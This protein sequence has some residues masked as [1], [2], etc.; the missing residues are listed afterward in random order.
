MKIGFAIPRRKR[1]IGKDEMPSWWRAVNSQSEHDRNYMAFLAFTGCRLTES[2]TLDWR[3][4]NLKR[5]IFTL[6]NPKNHEADVILPLPDIVLRMIRPHS[7]KTGPVFAV[8][9]VP[10]LIEKVRRESGVQFSAHDLR[11]TFITTGNSLDI[12]VY[13]IKTLVNH[14]VSASDVTGRYD[15]P[16]AD[17][18]KSASR[19]I[20]TEL[21]RQMVNLTTNVIHINK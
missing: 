16:S 18:L 5:G 10:W 2:K 7:A 9:G 11:R 6:V 17:R 15:I 1:V 8:G 14:K 19:R 21:L 12:S 13:T 3:N 20:E 4:V